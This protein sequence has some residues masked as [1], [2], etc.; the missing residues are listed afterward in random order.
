[1]T[2]KKRV[3]AAAAGLTVLAAFGAG[4]LVAR[5]TPGGATRNK[6]S[7]AGNVQ[8]VP[9]SGATVSFTFTNTDDTTTCTA[10]AGSPSL[11]R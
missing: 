6:L 7:F 8:P 1:M 2:N 4:V 11:G 9:A 5:A 3:L 10:S